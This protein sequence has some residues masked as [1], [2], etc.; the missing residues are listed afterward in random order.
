MGDVPELTPAELG[1]LLSRTLVEKRDL[2]RALADERQTAT[3]NAEGHA[4]EI[5]QLQDMVE[6]EVEARREAERELRVLLVTAAGILDPIA[7]HR[8]MLAGIIAKPS[9]EAII[10]IYGHSALN[11]A[12]RETDGLPPAP[13]DVPSSTKT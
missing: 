7:V 13:P 8:N 5:R 10:H 3:L 1:R 12:L 11:A 4:R 6:V 2:E 9:V